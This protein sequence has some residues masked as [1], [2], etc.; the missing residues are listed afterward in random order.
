M[1]G[2]LFTN[3]PFMATNS[4]K[5]LATTCDP[6]SPL[7]THFFARAN[8]FFTGNLCGRVGFGIDSGYLHLLRSGRVDMHDASGHHATLE[9]PCLLFFSR[10]L[11]HWFETDTASGADLACATVLFDNMAFNPVAQALPSRFVCKLSELDSAGASIELLF[12]EAFAKRPARQE[13]LNRLFE[14]VLIELLRTAIRRGDAAAGFLRGLAH[15]R[16]AKTL[17][18]VH[19]EP[20]RAWNLLTMSALAGMSRSGFADTFRKEVGETPL[21]YLTRWR[22]SVAQAMLKR[23]TPLKMI[24]G[25]VGY[26]SHAGFL[27]AFRQITNMAPREWLRSAAAAPTLPLGNP[28]NTLS[29]D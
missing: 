24:S 13:A 21:N 9:E 8:V 19:S 26:A 29:A 4:P 17:S 3:S 23:G 28:V 2:L 10:P 14:I 15:P 20:G 25:E 5:E 6:L 27:R 7:L 16:L 1:I 18:A 11:K 12:D 22:M